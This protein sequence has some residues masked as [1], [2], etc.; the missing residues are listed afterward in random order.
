MAKTPTTPLR[1]TRRVVTTPLKRKPVTKE[2][3]FD[4]RVESAWGVMHGIEQTLGV[5][6]VKEGKAKRG[7]KE[8]VRVELSSARDVIG[9]GRKMGWIA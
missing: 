8:V 9:W 4:P 7:Q 2:V 1:A 3:K 6:S 5:C